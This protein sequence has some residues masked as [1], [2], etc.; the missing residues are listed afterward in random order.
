MF[1]ECQYTGKDNM[2]TP[3]RPNL[4]YYCTFENLRAVVGLM[5]ATIAGVMQGVMQGHILVTILRVSLLRPMWE[6]TKCK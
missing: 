6:N 1:R 3:F 5:H 4:M 2:K